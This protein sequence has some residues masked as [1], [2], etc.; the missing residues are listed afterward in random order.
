MTKPISYP[1]RTGLLGLGVLSQTSLLPHFNTRDAQKK[2]DL[3]AVCDIDEMRAKQTAEEFQIPEYYISLDEM[4]NQAE[5]DAILICTPTSIHYDNAMKSL[6]AGLHVYL[7]KPIA[8][9]AKEAQEL[10]ATAERQNRV[11]VA[12]PQQIINP[13]LKFA[14]EMISDGAVGPVFWALCV[15]DHPGPQFEEGRLGEEPQN[16]I[17]PS[18]WFK[19]GAGPVYNMSVYTLHS[20]TSLLGPVEKVTALSGKRMPIREWKNKKIKTEVDDNT[21]MLL[22][23]GQS[24]FSVVS[25]CASHPGK[26][27]TWGHMSIFGSNGALEIYSTNPHEPNFINEINHVGGQTHTFNDF[28]PYIPEN[29]TKIKFPFIY[30]DIM[31]FLDCVNKGEYPKQFAEQACHIVE[32]IEKAYTSA[33]TGSVQTIV[34]R[35]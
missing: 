5:L 7:Q 19:K 20:I 24:I 15:T 10:I 26:K 18:W 6:S 21:L 28:G 33:K 3:T 14:K 9:S 30:G 16:K 13:T 27:I 17:D 12:S 2:M 4:L 31:Y 34:S 11:I 22:D 1:I 23:F 8:T 25:G 29:H 35:F 32:V